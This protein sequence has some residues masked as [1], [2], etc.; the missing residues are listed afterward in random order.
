MAMG[1]IITIHKDPSITDSDYGP[2]MA[3]ADL[4]KRAMLMWLYFA[5]HNNGDVIELTIRNVCEQGHFERHVY[6]EGFK[7]LQNKL[8]IIPASNSNNN[9]FIFYA[10]PLKYNF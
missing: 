10:K 8:F 7:E 5:T 6:A 4:G 3:D 2:I 1:K 9:E